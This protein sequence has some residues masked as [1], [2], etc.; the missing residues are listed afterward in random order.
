MRLP[1][2]REETIA[3]RK[4]SLGLCCISVIGIFV[5][6]YSRTNTVVAAEPVPLVINSTIAFAEGAEAEPPAWPANYSPPSE[7]SASALCAEGTSFSYPSPGSPPAV[8]S[9]T[10]ADMKAGLIAA[11]CA[12]WLPDDFSTAVALAGSFRYEGNA[13]G[14]LKRFGNISSLRGMRY[15]SITDKKWQVM[16]T[17]ASAIRGPEGEPRRD[18]T[19]AELKSGKPLYFVQKDNR[20]PKPIT[21]LMQIDGE[22]RKKQVV[23]I[24]N[25]SSLKILMIPVLKQGDIQSVYILEQL[26][27]RVWGYFSVLGIRSSFSIFSGSQKDSWINRT[28]AIYSHFTGIQA[29]KMSEPVHQVNR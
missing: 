4:L 19:L 9:W 6:C 14:L 22:T 21:F 24:S 11:D 26:S 28:V 17:D 15:W 18:F 5:A 27:P 13:A 2:K 25:V 29:D 1:T 10:Q 8:Q 7:K 23:R 20:S 3:M 12:K 16:I